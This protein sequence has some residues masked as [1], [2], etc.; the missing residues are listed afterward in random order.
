VLQNHFPKV[1]T[2]VVVFPN[3]LQGGTSTNTIYVAQ[4]AGR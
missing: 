4:V 1:S 3:P 2:D